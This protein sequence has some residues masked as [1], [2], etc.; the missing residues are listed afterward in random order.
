MAQWPA[1]VLEGAA[2]RE[3]G[4]V[5]LAEGLERLLAHSTDLF[6]PDGS[7]EVPA[8]PVIVDGDRVHVHPDGCY[9]AMQHIA[10]KPRPDDL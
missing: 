6:G 4:P 9:D 5:P 8:V 7:L 1:Y 2:R 3:R 10:G